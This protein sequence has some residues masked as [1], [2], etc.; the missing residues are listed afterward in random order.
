MLS[1]TCKQATWKLINSYAESHRVTVYINIHNMY[2]MFLKYHLAQNLNI[3]KQHLNI[4]IING[5]VLIKSAS[6]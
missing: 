4:I 2:S 6:Y 3:K 5:Y 1:L